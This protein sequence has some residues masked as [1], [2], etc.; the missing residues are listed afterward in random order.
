M[1]ERFL[2]DGIKKYP[3]NREIQYYL[4]DTYEKSGASDK[5][6]VLFRKILQNHTDE[7]L[8]Q[9]RLGLLLVKNN[10][11]N[12]AISLFKS[13]IHK[14]LPDKWQAGTKHTGALFNLAVSYEM[15]GNI[16]QAKNAYNN[17]LEIK[18]EYP[19][20]FVRLGALYL[21]ECNYIKAEECF[22]NTI[23]LDK[24]LLEAHLALSRIYVSLNDLESCVTSCDEL[25]KCLDLPRNIAIDSV[26]DLSKLYVNIGETLKARQKELLAN[27][28]F[29]IA[30]FLNADCG[31]R[32]AE[33]GIKSEIPGPD[34]RA[35]VRLGGDRTRAG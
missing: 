33:C 12:E 26:S 19:E 30:T 9:Y 16:A 23:K 6:L 5:A 17:M 21:N 20:V 7:T 8:A 15:G 22:L 11:F 29:E 25:L 24:Y 27:V 4:A 34:H 14:D 35:P 13:V 32:I 28:S 18:P 2:S 10:Q 31:L 3:E 1:A